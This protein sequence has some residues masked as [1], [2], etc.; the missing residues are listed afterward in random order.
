MSEPE[1]FLTKSGK[2]FQALADGMFQAVV[3]AL[4]DLCGG[5]VSFG[6]PAVS[7]GSA[8]NM[9]RGFSGPFAVAAC[10]ATGA[11]AGPFA[12][13]VDMPTARA[14]VALM[15]GAE[16][17]PDAA[18]S[19]AL[20]PDETDAFRELASN[21]CSAVGAVLRMAAPDVSAS[22]ASIKTAAGAK[23]LLDLLRGESVFIADAERPML[24]AC[25]ADL[26]A[27]A[28]RH[29]AGAAAGKALSKSLERILKIPIPVI[30]VLA[31][32]A[33]PFKDVLN[34]TEGSVIEFDK[35]SAEPLAL[36]VNDR[37]VGIGRVIKIGERFGLRIEEIGGPEDIVYKLR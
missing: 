23:E 27:A 31:E 3:E 20:E 16:T 22:L 1:N 24:L 15:L 36:L 26:C 33:V 5:K 13:V 17:P 12:W 11:I 32:K 2:E 35:S 18:K 10:E 14:L 21:A 6:A 19:T 28:L 37:K 34:L 7:T 29:G 8:D 9:P 25:G 4:N 30:V